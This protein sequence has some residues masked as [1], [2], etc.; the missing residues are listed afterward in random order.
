MPASSRLT[1]LATFFEAYSSHDLARL[2]ARSQNQGVDLPSGLTIIHARIVSAKYPLNAPVRL[3]WKPFR[4]PLSEAAAVPVR[5]LLSRGITTH[6]YAWGSKI[7]RLM[8]WEEVSR[9][10]NSD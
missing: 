7:S 9:Q 2:D 4:G 6:P 8:R 3:I 1:P 5:A 10:A